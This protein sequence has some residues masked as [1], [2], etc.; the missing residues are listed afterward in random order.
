MTV[1]FIEILC[2]ISSRLYGIILMVIFWDM[3]FKILVFLK[4]TALL[5]HNNY[6]KI[7]SISLKFGGD[8]EFVYYLLY[9][10]LG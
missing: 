6:S 8:V 1:K 4:M 9:E 5:S 2:K 3:V 10:L 7:V